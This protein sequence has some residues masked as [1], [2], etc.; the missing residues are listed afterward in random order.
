M[1]VKKILWSRFKDIQK[2]PKSQ[3]LEKGEN[4]GT[5]ALCLHC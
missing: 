3:N 2:S 1:R 5:I 4:L